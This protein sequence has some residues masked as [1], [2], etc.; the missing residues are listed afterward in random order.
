MLGHECGPL[1]DTAR[2]RHVAPL[3]LALHILDEMDFT[4]VTNYGAI[5]LS[6]Y[7]IDSGMIHHG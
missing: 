5:K 6:T 7:C 3:I 4:R 1:L 2:R